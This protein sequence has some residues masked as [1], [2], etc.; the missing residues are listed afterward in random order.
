[1]FYSF[2]EKSCLKGLQLGAGAFYTGDRLAGRS[3][4]T[5]VEN[6]TYRLM[7]LPDFVTVDLNAG[8]VAKAFSLRVKLSNLFN[9]LSYYAHD[10]NSINPIA[11]RQFIATFSYKL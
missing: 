9:Q 8:Y 10:D 5:T 2:D 3:T 4:R 7:P 6:D 11:P 1:V